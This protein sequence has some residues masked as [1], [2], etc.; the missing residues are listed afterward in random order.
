LVIKVW[1]FF[2][3]IRFFVLAKILQNSSEI[4]LGQK[5]LFLD[6]KP[7]F[8]SQKTLFLKQKQG[9]WGQKQGSPKIPNLRNIRYLFY[10]ELSKNYKKMMLKSN[11]ENCEKLVPT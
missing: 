10:S 11:L 5:P 8:L 2:G 4:I 6:Q 1:K 9:L 7:L 3:N